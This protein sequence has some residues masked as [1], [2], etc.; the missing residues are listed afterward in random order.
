MISSYAIGG[1]LDHIKNELL[2]DFPIVDQYVF[3]ESGDW[4]ER[5]IQYITREGVFAKAEGKIPDKWVLLVWNRDSLIE[6]QVHSRR[7]T[8]S[9]FMTTAGTELGA[10]QVRMGSLP[11]S[12]SIVC[13]DIEMAEWIEEYLFVLAGET[14][15]FEIDIP[16]FGKFSVSAEAVLDA[17]FEKL[18]L[19]NHGSATK[20]EKTFTIN[21]PVIL[22]KHYFPSIGGIGMRIGT[23]T[24]SD[25]AVTKT[26]DETLG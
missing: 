13:S 24:G 16:E 21:F 11:V 9:S 26:K 5:A 17:T 22:P 1:L 14:I 2:E 23:V 6:G 25:D 10:S 15:S 3:D 18:A 7:L 4:G 19:E 20:I 12:V 8:A